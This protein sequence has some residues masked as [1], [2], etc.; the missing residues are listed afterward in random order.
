MGLDNQHSFGKWNGM[1]WGLD[2]ES[3]RARGSGVNLANAPKNDAKN[4]EW[5][6]CCK[7]DIRFDEYRIWSV[8]GSCIPEL[9]VERLSSQQ[10]LRCKNTAGNFGLSARDALPKVECIS[11]SVTVKMRDKILN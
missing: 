8:N 3:G 2:T 11:V 10:W 7:E 6:S 4:G 9:Q 5:D 1:E